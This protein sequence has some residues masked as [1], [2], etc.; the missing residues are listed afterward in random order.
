MYSDDK[1]V[2]YLLAG[3]KAYGIRDIIASPGMQN[4][5][6]NASAQDDPYFRCFSI[7]DERGAAYAATG[8]AAE[9]GQPVVI[10]CTG[11]TASR[12]YLP[13]LTE[14][15]YRKLPIIALTFLHMESKFNLAPQYLDRTVSQNDVKA[16]EIFLNPISTDAQ[17]YKMFAD[18]HAALT[19]AKRGLGPV[20]IEVVNEDNYGFNAKSLP[21]DFRAIELHDAP[22]P[23]L[24]NYMAGKK[25]GVFIGN[26]KKFSDDETAALSDFAAGWNAAVFCDHTSRYHGKNKIMTACAVNAANIKPNPDIMIDIG[27][28]SGEYSSPK[29][30]YGAEVWRVQN[31]RDYGNRWGWAARF[32]DCKES[33]FFKAMRNDG[34]NA[35][36]YHA[37]VKSATDNIRVPD[38]PLSY[39]L[40][41]QKLSE[42]LPR[43][44]QLQIGGPN[45]RRNMNF[46][47]LDETI[48]CSANIG[49]FGI[50]GMVSTLLGQSL[51]APDRMHFALVGDLAFF[52]DMGALGS[53]HVK[54]NMR[55]I[56]VNNDGG[57]CFRLNPTLTAPLGDKVDSLIAAGGHN[58][59]GA[60]SWAEACGF[61]YMSADTKEKFLEQIADFC[62]M[63]SDRPMLFEVFVSHRDELA[64]WEALQ[65]GQEPTEF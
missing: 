28:I 40:I 7:V 33:D 45:S 34:K 65:A 26:H 5:A 22:A 6:F 62:Q 30:F 55:L 31:D 14:A 32:F 4:S 50:D 60:K 49:A 15:Y 18:L 24:R 56:V 64:G 1:L 58:R 54:N 38:L 59:G 8:M 19:T 47:R 53:R 43:G 3:L 36:D 57:E 9:S 13:A 42:C 52:Y 23:D 35:A 25:I 17:K 27:G 29:L 63:K 2:Q 12:N 41:C 20:H 11:A 44:C 21:S 10:T 46:F 48:D 16:M 39:A 61:A 51:V 37:G